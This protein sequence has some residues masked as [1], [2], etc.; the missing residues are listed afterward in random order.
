MFWRFESQVACTHYCLFESQQSEQHQ[1][2]NVFYMT[3]ILDAVSGMLIVYI[4]MAPGHEI[5]LDPSLWLFISLRASQC[6]PGE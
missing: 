1:A 5:V 4:F 6:L 3:N 2:Q